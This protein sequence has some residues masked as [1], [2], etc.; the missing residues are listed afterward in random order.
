[1]RKEEITM[2]IEDVKYHL[3]QAIQENKTRVVPCEIYTSEAVIELLNTFGSR[4]AGYM[5]VLLNE[6]EK[7]KEQERQQQKN[8]GCNKEQL[9]E[10]V[11]YVMKRTQD[12]IQDCVENY[13][14]NDYISYDFNESYGEARITAQI[15]VPSRDFATD[16]TTEEMIE[17]VLIYV[18]NESVELNNNEEI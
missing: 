8:F 9:K 1:M 2:A 4:L 18:L 12:E 15:N 11:E 10:I 14:F 5:D 6:D 3:I 7:Q 16:T 17:D 13:D